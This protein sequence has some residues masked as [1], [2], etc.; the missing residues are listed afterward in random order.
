MKALIWD[1]Q[2]VRLA[3]RP[4]PRPGPAEVVL[5]LRVAGICSTDLEIVRGYLGFTGVLGHELCGT[6]V[7]GPAAWLG[8]RVV[9]EINAA[10]GRCELCRRGL[11]RHCPERR[12]LGIAGLDGAFAERVAVPVANL[13]EVPEGL[14]DRA[15]VFTEPLAAAGEI[16]AQLRR[17]W[18]STDVVVLGDGKLGLLVAQV[19]A[20]AGSRLRLVGKH[21]AHL[22]LARQ[23]GL[24]AVLLA[25]W[26]R[27][28]ADVTVDA[29]GQSSGLAL[30]VAATR[31][32]GTVVLKSTVAEPFSLDLAPVV[33][34]EI[35]IVGSRCGPFEPALAALAEGRVAVEPLIAA[36]YP[37]NEGVAALR[38]AAEPG[39]LK[40]LLT[41]D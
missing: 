3:A 35:S 36:T 2:Q 37:L 31:P 23:L 8:K 24:E 28:K 27:A 26:D 17:D 15:A 38:H 16:L 19:L 4:E 25:D 6:V 9:S 13:H 5:Q 32:R 22:E 29:T 21:E 40:V 7:D 41:A 10:C 20:Q 39:T 30:A 12:V 33:I 1:G 18:P 14:P 34:D 11:G